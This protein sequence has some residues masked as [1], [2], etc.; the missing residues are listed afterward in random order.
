MSFLGDLLRVAGGVVAVSV[1]TAAECLDD[2]VGFIET[3]PERAESVV[4][5]ITEIFG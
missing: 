4:D 2:P 1:E 5:N 3:V